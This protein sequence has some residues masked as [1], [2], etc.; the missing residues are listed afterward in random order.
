MSDEKKNTV[1]VDELP[2]DAPAVDDM[3]KDEGD[4]QAGGRVLKMPPVAGPM[5][6][7]QWEAFCKGEL[8]N[9]MIRYSLQKVTAEDGSGKK[10]VVS[11][12]NKG[13]YKVQVTSTETM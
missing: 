6:N 7:V 2:K 5:S 11:I 10:G 8:L 4:Q 9:F 3:F 1:D 12:N 13:E